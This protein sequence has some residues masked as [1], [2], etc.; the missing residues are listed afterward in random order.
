MSGSPEDI[1][2]D[3]LIGERAI[4]ELYRGEERKDAII[5]ASFP[6][7][8]LRDVSN[9]AVGDYNQLLE[10]AVRNQAHRDIMSLMIAVSAQD[11]ISAKRL[12]TSLE[13]VAEGK[14]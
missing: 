4:K 14:G 9:M 8:T 7:Y 13:K 1:D 5:L 3:R 6:Q 11:K 2:F 12:F 10:A